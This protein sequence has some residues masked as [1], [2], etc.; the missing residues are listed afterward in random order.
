[1]LYD[2]IKEICRQKGIS[3][4]YLEKVAGLGHGAITK[5]NTVSP[6]VRSLSKVAEVLECS[7]NDL[8]TPGE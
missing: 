8:L 7:V 3:I 2:K 1:M 5:W 6:S 4:N